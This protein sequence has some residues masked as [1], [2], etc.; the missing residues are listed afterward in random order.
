MDLGVFLS[1][2]G[3]KSGPMGK[4]GHSSGNLDSITL[5]MVHRL[6]L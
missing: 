3:E 2:M 1:L 4:V 6:R 5:G